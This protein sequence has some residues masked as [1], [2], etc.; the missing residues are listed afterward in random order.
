M[1]FDTSGYLRRATGRAKSDVAN[2]LVSM[3]LQVAQLI[4]ILEMF[5]GIIQNSTSS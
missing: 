1:N 4:F 3:F 2:K 5:I